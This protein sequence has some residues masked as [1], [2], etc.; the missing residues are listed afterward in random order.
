M[1]RRSPIPTAPK[2]PPAPK[3]PKVSAPAPAPKPAPK[4]AVKSA[5]GGGGGKK[6]DGG[7]SSYEKLLRKQQ[8]EATRKENDA[9]RKAEQ[10]YRGQALTLEQQAKALQRALQVDY[11]SARD[12][13]LRGVERTQMLQDEALMEGYSDRLDSLVGSVVDN[14]T[15]SSDATVGNTMNAARERQNA[16]SEIAAQGAGETDMLRAQMMSLRNWNANQNE[17]NRSYFDSL[18]S[19]NASLGDLNVDTKTARINLE[20]QANADKEQLWTNYFNQRSESYTQLG[21]IRGQQADYYGMAAEQ[22]VGKGG[23]GKGGGGKGKKAQ[24]QS[25]GTPGAALGP[26]GKLTAM[27]GDGAGKKR[28]LQVGSQQIP[29][30]KL[31]KQGRP[32][33]TSTGGGINRGPALDSMGNTKAQETA[34]KRAQRAFLQSAK[35]QGKSWENEGV[36]DELMAWQ[37]REA[38]KSTVPGGNTG[39]VILGPQK[40]AEGATLRKW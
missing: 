24:L 10:R 8:A 3:V 19:I 15:A 5:A 27:A 38:F 7:G 31:N 6:D 1:A 13:K 25:R 37:G 14:D 16:M 4:P 28:Q 40:Q 11:A 2:A 23:G 17:V 21:N 29:G 30:A 22:Q 35:T 9:K 26:N 34:N 39:P 36:S 33:N 18:R 12:I 20:V 32:I